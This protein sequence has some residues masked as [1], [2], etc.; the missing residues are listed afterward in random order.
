MKKITR[1]QVNKE[2][3]GLWRDK[4]LIL[5]ILPALTI[6]IMF[7]YVPMTG[8][9]MA[10]KKFDYSLGMY[11]SPWVGLQNFK[12]LFANKDVFWRSTRNTIMYYVLLTVTNTFG[13]V[14]LAIALNELAFKRSAKIMQSIMILPTFISYV[15]ITMLVTAL[16]DYKVGMVNSLIEAGGG[17]KINFYMKPEWC[18]LILTII[19]NWKGTGYGSV[20]YLSVLAGIDPALYEAA[21]IDGA[22]GYQKMWYITIPH[23]TPMVSVMTILSL[24]NIMESS[25]GLF[26][27]VTKNIGALY[28][29]TQ[30]LSTFVYDAVRNSSSNY[31]TTSAVTFYQSI[32]AFVMIVTVNLIVRKKSPE[33]ALF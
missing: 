2:I 17:T 9:V 18:P 10:F 30:T 16:L 7:S 19:D 27:R 14:M 5:M 32:V 28:P 23:L 13:N 3:K 1:K 29:T 25:I 20:L 31:G 22:K 8:L 11:D 26:Y 6:L 15:A 4:Q 33:H 24:G 12:I 21:E